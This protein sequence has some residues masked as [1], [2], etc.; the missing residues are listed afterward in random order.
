MLIGAPWA[1]GRIGSTIAI[2][3]T[4]FVPAAPC[5]LLTR[6]R[7]H[8][9]AQSMLEV[10]AVALAVYCADGPALKHSP[11]TRD[12]YVTAAKE[13]QILKTA[14][15]IEARRRFFADNITPGATV[16]AIVRWDYNLPMHHR[17]HT[18]AL[19]EGRGWHGVPDMAERRAQTD[20]FFDSTT[21]GE[22]RFEILRKYG[23]HHIYTSVRYSSQIIRS[24][25][26]RAKLRA[27]SREG[28]I[29]T[30]AL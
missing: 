8:V 10:A 28:A 13:V 4:T 6:L 16:M 29:V 9:L 2:A 25:G 1:A 21:S 26:S 5:S 19:A 11:W 22:R 17:C 24:L 30:V 14:Q 27:A 23:I 18:L 3:L 20:E 7:R 15:A 12:A